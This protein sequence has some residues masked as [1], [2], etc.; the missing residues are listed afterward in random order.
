LQ[1][2]L[3][4]AAVGTIMPVLWLMLGYVGYGLWKRER[5]DG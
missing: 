1:A 5:K 4:G 2:F 3:F